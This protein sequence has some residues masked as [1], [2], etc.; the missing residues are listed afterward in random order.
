MKII[1]SLS[2]A[3]LLLL[4]GLLSLHLLPTELNACTA[5]TAKLE[6][7]GNTVESIT[8]DSAGYLV[9]TYPIPKTVINLNESSFLAAT[10]QFGVSVVYRE[11]NVFYFFDRKTSTRDWA[12]VYA[13]N[14]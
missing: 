3:I 1:L 4:G 11:N 12:V 13:Y 14:L 7:S 9:L 8:P 2:I 5:F 6:K 10:Q